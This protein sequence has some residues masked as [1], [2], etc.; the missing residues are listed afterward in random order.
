MKILIVTLGSIG[1]LMPFLPI[2]EGLRLRGH[3][4]VIASNASY[5]QLI[6][7]NGFAFAPIWESSQK[8]LDDTLAH[9]PAQA[10]KIVHQEMF[11][12][13][14]QATFD[15]IAPHA[16]QGNCAVLA[17][18]SAFGAQLAHEKLG[19]PIFTAYL[20][21]HAVEEGRAAGGHRLGFFPDWFGPVQKG[22]QPLGFPLFG[23]TA[24]PALP[25]EVEQFLAEGSAPVIF[26]P[27]S[28]MRKSAAFFRAS[29]E[30]SRQLNARAIFL[31]PY[32]DQ[33][34]TDLPGTI[35]HFSYVSLQRL[36]PRGA[37]LVHHGGI[38]T[39]AQ[40]LRAGIPQLI[41][42]VFFDQPDNARR[43]AALGVGQLVQN[44]DAKDVALRLAEILNSPAVRQ[45]CLRVKALFAAGDPVA[46]ICRMITA[47]A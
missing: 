22:L 23:D 6:R 21:P 2:A 16:R 46:D 12:R 44:Y 1:D 33:V 31:T 20:S 45:D 42:P 18:W 19:V 15:F 30:A 39:T 25:P 17:S 41:T 7:M 9:D 5:A 8:M 10:W 40:A 24:V 47:P 14:T 26:T 28:F 36:A 29:M 34:P 13:A 35:R 37:A 3:T 43:I 11:E 27:G 32:K 4:P 38:G